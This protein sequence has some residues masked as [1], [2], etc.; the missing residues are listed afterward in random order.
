M[1][2]PKTPPYLWLWLYFSCSTHLPRVMREVLIFAASFN[3]SP[4]FWV[5]EHLSEPARSTNDNLE[6]HDYYSGCTRVL[7]A[8]LHVN[9]PQY[10]IINGTG[11]HKL[12]T[13]WL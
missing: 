3:L 12:L 1:I 10:L 4:L 8:V 6:N 11:L 2:R 13:D 5:L 7:L 9:A